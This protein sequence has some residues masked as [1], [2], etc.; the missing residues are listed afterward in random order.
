MKP[1]ADTDIIR[2]ADFEAA[3]HAAGYD[4]VVVREWQPNQVVGTHTHPFDVKALVVRGEL[5]LSA[6]GR[7]RHVRAG[8]RFEL[9]RMCPHDERY[10]PEGATFWA[11]R[12]NPTA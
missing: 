11:A 2:Y 3:A 7:T 6:E 8:Q 5:W 10:G 9:T 1:S 4:E 12:R